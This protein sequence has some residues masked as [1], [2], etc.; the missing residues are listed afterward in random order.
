[1]ASIYKHGRSI[2]LGF[3]DI[4]GKRHDRSLRLPPTA[5][6]WAEAKNVKKR[7]EVEL[8]SD[9]W[10]FTKQA[11]SP[12]ARKTLTETFDE[13]LASGYERL[14]AASTVSLLHLSVSKFTTLVG[15]FPLHKISASTMLLFRDAAMARD[16]EVNTACWLRHLSIV[17]SYAVRM[18]AIAVNPIGRTIRLNPPKKRPVIIRADDLEKIWIKGLEMWGPE[19]VRQCQFLLYTG[20]RAG[21]SC[22]FKR[23]QIDFEMNLLVYNN[24]KK[25]RVE[26]FPIYSALIPI[27]EPARPLQPDDFVFH[28]RSVSGISHAFHDVVDKLK[29]SPDYNLHGLKR[30]FV[31]RLVLGG[32]TPALAHQLAHHTDFKTTLEHYTAWDLELQRSELERVVGQ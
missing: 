32:I 14:H 8:R 31:T 28:Y 20:F 5:A 22:D 9:P 27:L 23:R 2:Y 17:F 7:L 16:G 12:S 26:H 18:G 15:D 11:R 19:F 1:M 6:G 10:G 13:M 30:N 3:Y 21:D 4:T 25:R 24:Q 29:C